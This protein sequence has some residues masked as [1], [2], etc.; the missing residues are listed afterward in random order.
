MKVNG[1]CYCGQI[2]YRAEVDPALVEIC[3]C[4]DCQTLS[5]SAFR[6]VVPAMEGS[7][8]LLSGTPRTYVK[9]AENGNRR[10][11]AFCAECGTSIYST[12]ADG[13]PQTIGLRVGTIR[14]RDQLPPKKQYWTRSA[15]RWVM[16]L[17]RIEKVEKQ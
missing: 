6:I 3:H 8:E 4:T 16:D 7:F 5:G 1:A 14:Q 2:R 12:N 10:I 17:D 13:S 15:H 11:Q 9:T